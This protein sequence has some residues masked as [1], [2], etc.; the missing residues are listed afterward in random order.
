MP[1]LRYKDVLSVKDCLRAAGWD[2]T[3]TDG[4]QPAVPKDTVLEQ[5]PG[6]GQS[7]LPATRSSS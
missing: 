1:D 2:W 4:G 3:V 7:V 6:Q 5:Y